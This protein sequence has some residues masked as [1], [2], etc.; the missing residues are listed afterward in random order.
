MG[1]VYLVYYLRADFEGDEKPKGGPLE[2][3]FF[4]EGGWRKGLEG[5]RMLLKPSSGFL[6]KSARR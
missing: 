2:I 4:V 6:T 1:T 5:V 3:H